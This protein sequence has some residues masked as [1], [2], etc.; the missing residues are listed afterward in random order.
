MALDLLT[1]DK[2][3]YRQDGKWQENLQLVKKQCSLLVIQQE[4]NRVTLKER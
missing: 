4:N 3:Q 2:Y 1:I